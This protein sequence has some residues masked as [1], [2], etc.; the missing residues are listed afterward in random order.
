MLKCLFSYCAYQHANG[1]L[2]LNINWHNLTLRLEHT[3][4]GR[5]LSVRASGQ[6]FPGSSCSRSRFALTGILEPHG[7]FPKALTLV[8]G[9]RFMASRLRRPFIRQC[10]RDQKQ[11]FG[12]P[13]V[14]GLRP[15]ARIH[16]KRPRVILVRL[17]GRKTNPDNLQ[18]EWSVRTTLWKALLWGTLRLA[19][20]YWC[21][22]LNGCVFVPVAVGRCAP[23]PA[24]SR[25]TGPSPRLW[26]SLDGLGLWPSAWGVPW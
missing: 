18:A 16:L 12:M 3:S 22:D 19:A 23:S 7:A 14:S 20:F 10:Q 5:V 4:V 26:H 11:F 24:S 1:L 25:L 13:G 9:A 17:V 6:V 15:W 21:G 2:L 8:W